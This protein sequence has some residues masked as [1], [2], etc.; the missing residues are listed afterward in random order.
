MATERFLRRKT[1]ALVFGEG[2]RSFCG[3]VDPSNSPTLRAFVASG[4][5]R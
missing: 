5:G 3:R 4:L 1:F 2:L